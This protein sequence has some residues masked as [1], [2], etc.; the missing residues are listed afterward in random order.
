MSLPK[1][2]V[3]LGHFATTDNLPTWVRTIEDERHGCA[4][5]CYMLL[6]DVHILIIPVRR[7]FG[8]IEDSECMWLS[9][10]VE[11]AVPMWTW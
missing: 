3:S 4:I 10:A 8:H 6:F 9:S 7:I 1:L 11:Q 2:L 5:C